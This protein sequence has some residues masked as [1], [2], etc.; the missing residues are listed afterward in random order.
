MLNENIINYLYKKV[1]NII[2]TNNN[3]KNI[4]E[5]NIIENKSI[6][7]KT[8]IFSQRD[9][10]R[11]NINNEVP[12]ELINCIYDDNN[13]DINGSLIGK[14]SNDNLI[15]KYVKIK[16]NY[17][18]NSIILDDLNNII[19]ITFYSD[20][21]INSI[22]YNFDIN[23]SY[24]YELYRPDNE[25]LLYPD[26]GNWIIDNEAGILIF[27]TNMNINILENDIKYINENNSPFITFYSYN[28]K[29]GLYPL[30]YNKSNEIEIYNNLNINENI[31]IKNNLTTNGIYVKNIDKY[32]I[33]SHNQIINKN[34]EL[35]FSVNNEWFK[36]SND[37]L[38]QLEVEQLIY[39]TDNNIIDINKNVSVIEISDFLLEDINIT[40]P[41]VTK[42]GIEKTI[43]MG[44]SVSN[45]V[46]NVYIVVRGTFI[47]MNG[48][49][50]SFMNVKFNKTG[51]FIKLISIISEDEDVFGSKQR[52]WQIIIDNSKHI[53]VEQSNES[54]INNYEIVLYNTININILN[55]TKL[56]SIIELSD[57]IYEDV[58]IILPDVLKPGIKK[59]IIMGTSTNKYLNGNHIIIYGNFMDVSGIGPVQMNLKLYNT[60]QI[61]QLIS[62]VR[63]NKNIYQTEIESYW[64][65][66]R[67]QF[68]CVD[69]FSEINYEFTNESNINS[70]LNLITS[71][72][73]TIIYENNY[74]FDNVLSNLIYDELVLSYNTTTYNIDT[75]LY[76]DYVVIELANNLITN[77]FIILDNCNF[78]AKELTII[79]GKSVNKYINNYNI[80]IT[81]KYLC[82]SGV[83]PEYLDIE[84]NQS[85]NYVHLVSIVQKNKNIDKY[86]EKYWFI[87]TGSFDDSKTFSVN[88]IDQ[89]LQDNIVINQSIIDYKKL[90][91]KNTL[92]MVLTH[93]TLIELYETTTEDIII[94]LPLL[95]MP[96]VHYHII[97]GESVKKYING[98]KI[99]LV[100]KF[101]YNNTFYNNIYFTNTGQYIELISIINNINIPINN[102]DKYWQILFN[103]FQSTNYTIETGV[104]NLINNT[105]II[106]INNFIIN[107]QYELLL[108]DSNNI[109]FIDINK[110]IT[111]IE[112]DSTLSNDIFFILPVLNNTGQKKIITLSNNSFQFLN[113][114]NI[115]I[116]GLFMNRNGL[117]S[118]MFI[119]LSSSNQIIKLVSVKIV[120]NIISDYNYYWQIILCDYQYITYNNNNYNINF[121]FLSNIYSLPSDNSNYKFISYNYYI[122][123]IIPN[124][125]DEIIILELYDILNKDAYILLPTNNNIG[126]KKIIMTGHSFN[127]YSNGFSIILY[128]YYI[129]D[130]GIGPVYMNLKFTSSGQIIYLIS[131]IT[132]EY[133]N[134]RL[135]YWQIIYGHFLSTDTFTIANGILINFEDPGKI[136]QN[137]VNTLNETVLEYT[138]DE[139]INFELLIYI[140]GSINVISLNKK[141][142]IVELTD[143]LQSDIY[144]ILPNTTVIGFY[145]YILLGPSTKKY[146]NGYNIIIYSK[147]IST[148]GIGPVF[149]NLKMN[150]PGQ[151]L[152]LLSLIDFNSSDLTKYWQFIISNFYVYDFIELKNDYYINYNLNSDYNTL[153]DPSYNDP[154]IT[155]N[156]NILTYDNLNISNNLNVFNL[157]ISNNLNIIN[158]N[159]LNVS[160]IYTNSL[161]FNHYIININLI[162]NISLNYNYNYII[163]QLNSNLIENKIITLDIPTQIGIKKTI[164]LDSSISTYINQYSIILNSYFLGYFNNNNY[165]NISNQSS[166]IFNKSGEKIHLISMKSIESIYYWFIL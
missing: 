57:H 131:S 142:T 17:V 62:I 44:Q 91:S 101:F 9:I 49:G 108:Y 135:N 65:L 160:N 39:N 78:N 6:T 113:N 164:I 98:Y 102:S 114:Y 46:N 154:N 155:Q 10:Y 157:H 38:F 159:N 68:D 85:G 56:I 87:L 86:G 29:I 59:D 150:T 40:L 158:S 132:E 24:V 146:L 115:Y 8:K 54:S 137:I 81:G 95:K 148:E 163:L 55:I 30:T 120:N 61:I 32:P 106:Q 51:Q 41:I 7:T 75:S 22:P 118:Y 20:K 104:L 94:I 48:D 103:N 3:L 162:N 28:G 96:A 165:N 12:N 93:I 99:I 15:K 21:L 84:F 37:K 58:Y 141:I 147:Y 77:L 88:I 139:L 50:P 80:I 152:Y 134:E 14:T 124:D 19:S 117:I 161:H 33:Y 66:T 136:G 149:M 53:I 18:D 83:G 63:E 73:Q 36:L 79:M 4:E 122:T 138:T 72:Q 129:N 90:I 67:A 1:F 133:N 127:Y 110:N 16:L 23:G 145:K 119:Q 125:S 45:F 69:E 25:T 128:S 74:N 144:L 92:N 35:Y 111:L 26:E 143:Y 27:N 130:N 100:G 166:I 42:N 43:I 107:N 153:V 89:I 121:N 126:Q 34:N 52:Y 76:K 82:A 71:E 5:V 70:Q 31:I 11:D 47:N 140:H 116:Y 156:I 109:N 60:G 151:S 105:D 112:L 64:Q 97:M 13:D 2:T 123:N